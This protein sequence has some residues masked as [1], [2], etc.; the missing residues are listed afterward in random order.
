MK[1]ITIDITPTWASTMNIWV[2]VIL[3][4]AY[5]KLLSKA[6]GKKAGEERAQ[7]SETVQNFRDELATLTKFADEHNAAVKARKNARTEHPGHRGLTAYDCWRSRVPGF[8]SPGSFQKAMYTAFQAADKENSE[9]LVEA[10]PQW[11]SDYVRYWS[12]GTDQIVEPS[13]FTK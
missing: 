8:E 11:F 6:T 13:F 9:K 3:P 12:S 4:D 7:A 2:N 10:F 5:A 1:K